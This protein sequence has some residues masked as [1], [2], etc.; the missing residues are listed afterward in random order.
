MADEPLRITPCP[1][2]GE[3]VAESQAVCANCGALLKGVWPPPPEGY[4]P[5]P[6]P[7]LPK[8]L[9]GQ[10]WTDFLLGAAGQYLT[11]L[12]TARVLIKYVP[13]TSHSVDWI[14]RASA[15]GGFVLTEIF[16]AVVFGLV[17]YYGLR[18]FYPVV[19]RGSGYATIVLLVVLLG[20][21]FT[22]RP[23]LY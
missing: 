5:L 11:H 3:I 22:C 19:A 9:T 15:P 12:A 10:V 18:R 23:L 17:T 2:C 8:T 4:A 6:P 16:W 14:T 13:T 21:F 7:L 1:H 20:A